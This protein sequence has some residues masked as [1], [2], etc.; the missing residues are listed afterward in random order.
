MNK[1]K[2]F[3]A[4]ALA[5]ATFCAQAAGPLTST[6]A[7]T[8][9]A[10][11]ITGYSAG[12]SQTHSIAGDF[13]DV[14][15]LTGLDGLLNVDG[16]L[17]TAGRNAMDISFSSIA[18]NGQQFDL[19]QTVIGGYAGFKEMASLGQVNLDGPLVLTVSG[20]AG[21]PGIAD[22]EAISASYSGS[23]NAMTVPEPTGLVLVATA[24][25]A[26]GFVSRRRSS[27]NAQ[28]SA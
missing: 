26:A 19:S 18:L 20:H 2:T 7:V 28:K 10:D 17:Q 1:T 12:I 3:L 23:V 21:G 27:T 13:V 25:A 22:G 8:L 14:F 15:N 5:L 24:L 6:N 4:A 9:I 16:L 11:G